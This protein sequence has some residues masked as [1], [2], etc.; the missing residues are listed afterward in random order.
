MQQ[1]AVKKLSKAQH[2]YK[3]ANKKLR[4]HKIG[5]YKRKL[6]RANGYQKEY[7][8]LIKKINELQHAEKLYKSIGYLCFGF[9]AL[10]TGYAIYNKYYNYNNNDEYNYNC[11]TT[12]TESISVSTSTLSNMDINSNNFEGNENKNENKS[13]S[14][15][16]ESDTDCENDYETKF[17]HDLEFYLNK[18]VNTNCDI[19]IIN[20]NSNNSTNTEKVKKEKKCVKILKKIDNMLK[21]ELD[22]DLLQLLFELKLIANANVVYKK[23]LNA[24]IQTVKDLI[25]IIKGKSDLNMIDNLNIHDKDKIWNQ[26]VKLRQIENC[27]ILHTDD[28]KEKK[29]CRCVN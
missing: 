14:S 4:K 23:F 16:S 17:V 24:N 28:T 29:H 3:I 12:S 18:Y 8:A 11:K 26:I 13:D 15:D 20:C 9:T 2:F 7:D 10:A 19:S 6:N 1:E 27:Q 22:S 21:N 25:Q 5:K